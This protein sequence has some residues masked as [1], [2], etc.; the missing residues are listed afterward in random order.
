MP[1]VAAAPGLWTLDHDLRLAGLRM[2]TRMSVLR[3]RDGGLWLHSPVPIDDAVAAE[4][5]AL[6]P[7]RGLVAPNRLHHLFL[8][9]AATRWPGAAVYGAPGLAEKVKGLPPL[10]DLPAQGELAPGI[11]VLRV[12][13]APEMTEHL[14]LHAES[15]TLLLT[16]L[17]FHFVDVDHWWTRTFMGLN[18][19]YGRLTLSRLG[20]SM[21]KDKAALRASVDAALALPFVRIGLC[22]GRAIEA[23]GPARLR[24]AFAWLQ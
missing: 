9:A 18:D 4:I 1:L 2:G 14:L 20:K 11:A 13:G 22:H 21:V 5:N 10:R 16:D 3:A 12:E 24:E 15:A 23:D 8:G 7:V 6:G 19:A 17:C